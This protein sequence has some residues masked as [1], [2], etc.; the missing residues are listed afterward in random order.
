MHFLY[1]LAIKLYGFAIFFASPFLP[2]AKKWVQGR[3]NWQDISFD[4]SAYSSSKFRLWFHAA[5]LGEF[6]QGVEVLSALKKEY[7]YISI[8][9]SFFS[10]SGYEVCLRKKIDFI[11]EIVYLPLDTPSN[12]KQFIDKIKPNLAIFVK[13][14]FWFNYI[15]ELN[16]R[17]IPSCFISVK[18][19]SNHYF[20][21]FWASWFRKQLSKISIFFVQDEFSLEF[22]KEIGV[23]EVFHAGDTR[24][25]RVLKLR[26]EEFKSPIVESFFYGELNKKLILIGSSWAADEDV[27]L[28]CIASDRD[29]FD[30][31]K[32]I[33]APHEVRD[34]R[35]R[36]LY[37][38]FTEY[39]VILFSEADLS[40]NLA[41][42]NIL[43]IDR[44]GV[45][46]K[47]YRYANIAYIG[48]G[49]G[50]GIHNVLEA[51]VYGKPIIWGKKYKK[52][53]EAIDL[54]ALGGGF[55]ISNEKDLLKILALLDNETFYMNTS[56]ISANYVGENAGAIN[57]ILAKL[58][59]IITEDERK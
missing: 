11:D 34:E 21:S 57:I 14:E 35:I 54:L 26:L 32:L 9:V 39:G 19:R 30:K 20:A 51:A 28:N 37:S 22:L 48:G 45:L 31:Y 23:K 18:L 16:K 50:H 24:F 40:T 36:N 53:K 33:I 2:K 5:S 55:S 17:V 38:K 42:Y 29:F 13:Y 47:M 7:P 3:R 41:E 1:N 43:I 10:P 15:I 6:E 59:C 44:I 8:I 25:D 49:F 56:S 46:S 27:F 58:A 52:F 12:A 4:N